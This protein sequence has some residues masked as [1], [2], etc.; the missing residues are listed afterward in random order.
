MY[1]DIMLLRY[2][3]IMLLYDFNNR[4]GCVEFGNSTPSFQLFCKSKILFYDKKFISK[5]Y[6]YAKAK[7][8]IGVKIILCSWTLLYIIE[9]LV[10][11]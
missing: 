9:D 3:C 2:T 11:G 1:H 10:T 5:L 8:E 7:K 4:I 6:W